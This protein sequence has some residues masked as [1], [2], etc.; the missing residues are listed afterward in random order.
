MNNEHFIDV[1]NDQQNHISFHEL[2]SYRAARVSHYAQRPIFADSTSPRKTAE[3][4][5]K[6]ETGKV[7]GKLLVVK[8]EAGKEHSQ[9]HFASFGAIFSEHLGNMQI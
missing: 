2:M 4:L 1:R 5:G 7:A 6:C 8:W 3:E 9:R